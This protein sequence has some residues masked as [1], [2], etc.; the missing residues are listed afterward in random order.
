MIYMIKQEGLYQNKVNFSLIFTCNCKIVYCS[1]V[2]TEFLYGQERYRSQDH[3][4]TPYLHHLASCD[5][6]KAHRLEIKT[7]TY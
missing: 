1:I 7:K 3:H 2:L 6:F 5:Y 4:T